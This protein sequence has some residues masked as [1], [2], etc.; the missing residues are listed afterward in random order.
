[1]KK[2]VTCKKLLIY[3][4]QKNQD[5]KEKILIVEDEFILANGLRLMLKEAGFDVCEIAGS[6]PKAREIILLEKPTLVILDIHLDGKLSGIDLAKELNASAIGFIYLSANSNQVILEAA[7][8][9]EPYGFLVKP[10][11][12][13]DLLIAIE[14]AQYRQRQK[15]E[16]LNA[17]P[18][19]SNNQQK[20][21]TDHPAFENIIG[22]SPA[23]LQVFDQLTRVA[24]M[25]TSVLILGESGTGKEKLAYA[26]H[27][28]SPRR[29]NP[30][31]IVN[32]A[33][34]PP[35]LVE[36]E[37]F[38]HE[39]GA[40]TGAVAQRKGKFEMAHEG[41]IFLDEIGELPID[42]Q[43][44]L[45]RVLQEKQIERVGGNKSISVNVRI[46]A[47]TNRNL[48]KEVAEGR[49]RI[50]LYYRLNVFP[51]IV[52]PL[53]ERMDD[54]PLLVNYF[55]EEFCRKSGQDMKITNDALLQLMQYDWPGNIRELQHVVERSALM[56]SGRTIEQFLLPQHLNNTNS[57]SSPSQSLEDAERTHIINAL[58]KSNNKIYGA[59]GAAA[60]LKLPPT[61]LT[62][63]MKKLGIDKSSL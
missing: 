42:M 58:K 22:K 52:P 32:C 13:K 59:D 39:K 23:L 27:E 41:T 36:S 7:K 6:V 62:S 31:V 11:R 38:G 54:I 46:V 26:V 40:F 14:I 17:E 45:L 50:D 25:D 34:L 29:Y 28:L 16:L 57:L 55:I 33:V 30:F 53:R 20:A 5:L 44:K 19:R 9:T 3:I 60:L 1:M 10:Y 12:K 24:H 47:A 2:Q 21:T 63:K 35:N 56:A 51:L 4:F 37:L 61:T 15:M 8:I 49:F 48:E 18:A 43:A